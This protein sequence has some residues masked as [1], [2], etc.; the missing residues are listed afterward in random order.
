MNLREW[1]F[2][3]AA[4]LAAVTLMSLIVHLLNSIGEAIVGVL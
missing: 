1:G 3:T 2:V 4:L